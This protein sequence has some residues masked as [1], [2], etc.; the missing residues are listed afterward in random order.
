MADPEVKAALIA[1][2][3]SSVARGNVGAPSVFV[4]AEMWSGN[5]SLRDVEEAI[6]TA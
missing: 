4:G 5:D 1:N 2:T 6:Q 3:E